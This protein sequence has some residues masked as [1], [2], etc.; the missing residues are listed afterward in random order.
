VLEPDEGKLSSPVL[1]GLGASNGAR[2]LG[3]FLDSVGVLR[4]GVP[5]MSGCLLRNFKSERVALELFRTLDVVWKRWWT[6]WD[7]NPRPPHCERGKI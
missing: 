6:R 4:P 7:S 5:Q 1:R 3:K 2:P